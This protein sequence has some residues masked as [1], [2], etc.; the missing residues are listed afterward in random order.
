VTKATR[1]NVRMAGDCTPRGRGG[2]GDSHTSET[3]TVTLSASS[4]LGLFC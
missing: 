1:V 4:A 2:K 3:V